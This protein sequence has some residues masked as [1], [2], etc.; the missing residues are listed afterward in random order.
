MKDH[1]I[2]KSGFPLSEDDWDQLEAIYFSF[3]WEGPQLRYTASIGGTGRGVNGFTNRFPSYEDLII[4]T[5]FDGK[6][7]SYLASEENYRIVKALE[8]K[9]LIV[10]VVGNFAGNK[11]LRAIGRY[12]RERGAAVTAF[13]VS[14]VEQYLF[15]DNLFDAFAKNVASLPTNARS[16]FIR[17]VSERFG[18]SGTKTWSDG[19]AT[20]L[21]PIQAFVRDFE[22]GLL[23][24]YF[25]VNARSR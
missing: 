15:Q 2:K 16:S 11:A 20:A 4:Q 8:D 21:Y 19:R 9:N 6:P 3:F 13:Y 10:P 14:N 5:D 25:D 22:L 1:L 18:Y 23:G 17:S 12:A 24:S 7:R